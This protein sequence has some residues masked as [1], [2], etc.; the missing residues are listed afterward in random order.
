MIDPA[1]LALAGLEDAGNLFAVGQGVGT[2]DRPRNA[3]WN[4]AGDR[5]PHEKEPWQSLRTTRTRRYRVVRVCRCGHAN[6]CY[7]TVVARSTPNRADTTNF[8]SRLGG[9][10]ATVGRGRSISPRVVE[11]I[12]QDGRGSWSWDR[13]EPRRLHRRRNARINANNAKSPLRSNAMNETERN[14]WPCWRGIRPGSRGGRYGKRQECHQRLPNPSCGVVE[15]RGDRGRRRHK[16]QPT[17]SSGE[18]ETGSGTSGFRRE[19]PICP[20]GISGT[21]T[22][23]PI[24]GICPSPSPV[25]MRLRRVSAIRIPVQSSRTAK[26]ED[27]Q[28]V[29]RADSFTVSSGNSHEIGLS[30][31]RVVERKLQ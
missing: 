19:N 25:P 4:N 9:V 2:A 26:R 15:E 18:A 16:G 8:G 10:R 20:N 28:R 31:F 22:N 12:R 7:S 11:Q 6:G 1:Y 5:P 13:P 3:V 27:W 17:L 21:G 30:F 23:S 14:C 24:G 29:L